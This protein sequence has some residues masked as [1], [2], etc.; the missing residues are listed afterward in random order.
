MKS[1]SIDKKIR[2][3]AFNHAGSGSLLLD[4]ARGGLS[5]AAGAAH[6]L[7]GGDY[8]K[9]KELV[10]NKINSAYWHGL[11]KHL[12]YADRALG[13]TASKVPLVGKMFKTNDK[14]EHALDHKI[15]HKATSAKRMT[16]EELRRYRAGTR[17]LPVN[18]LTH[19]I[20]SVGKI[21]VPIAASMYLGEKLMKHKE[22]T[23]SAELS[24]VVEKSMLLKTAGVIRNLDQEKKAALDKIDDLEKLAS[25]QKTV[26]SLVRE[27]LLDLD[28]IDEK[29]AELVEFPER[30][31]SFFNESKSNNF[32]SLSK[33]QTSS[34]NP[35]EDFLLNWRS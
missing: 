3:E 30:A 19:P 35:L 11:G 22:Q 20:K 12:D 29:V 27:G 31:N 15:H 6:K 17:G 14:Y 21:A 10:S 18:R 23:K 16:E 28:E 33:S 32:G 8:K 7:V 13:N 26:L 1:S 34:S 24:V 9:T 2:Q 25:A 4:S 5:M